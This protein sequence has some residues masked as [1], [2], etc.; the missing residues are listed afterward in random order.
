MTVVNVLLRACLAVLLIWLGMQL[1]RRSEEK[2]QAE[3]D[4]G[5]NKEDRDV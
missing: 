5:D 4:S 3:R 1:V 2:K